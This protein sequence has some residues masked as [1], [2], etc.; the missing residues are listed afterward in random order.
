MTPT[1]FPEGTKPLHRPPSMSADQC[2]DL[3]VYA[4]EIEAGS[5]KGM[6]VVVAAWQPTEEE[7]M[8]I[9]A[10]KPVFV[11]MIGGMVPHFLTTTF[12]SATNPR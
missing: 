4:G 2:G 5:C 11:S 12:S 1:N 9:A 10:G 6:K 3:Q 7:K 8:H